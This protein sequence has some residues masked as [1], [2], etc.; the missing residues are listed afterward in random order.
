VEILTMTPDAAVTL[1]SI[2]HR[3]RRH[4][5][6]FAAFAL[7]C[8]SSAF[9][10]DSSIECAVKGAYLYK[11]LP[12]VEWPASVFAAPNAPL[13]ICIIGR[14]PFGA[15]FDKAV[16]EQ[17]IDTHP[18]VIRR[19]AAAGDASCQ[20]AFIGITEQQ[21]ESDALRAFDGKPVLTVTDSGAP[22]AGIFAFVVEQNHVRFDIDDAAAA[23]DGLSI[24]SKL[25]DLARKVKPRK[26]AP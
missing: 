1:A 9:A 7:L 20:I 25:L 16:A 6:L 26:A 8:I 18:V 19:D 3:L 10:G 21:A 23:K 15:G 5:S 17:H 4:A 13:A 14:N 11:L 12:F 24:S 22:L 2:A